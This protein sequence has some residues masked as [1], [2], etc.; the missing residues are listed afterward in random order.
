MDFYFTLY[1]NLQHDNLPASIYTDLSSDYFV[2]LLDALNISDT[3]IYCLSIGPAPSK[4]GNLA[5]ARARGAGSPR[6]AQSLLLAL[7]RDYAT[8]KRWPWTREGGGER[9]T[10]GT[11]DVESSRPDGRAQRSRGAR[12]DSVLRLASAVT[13]PMPAPVAR[14]HHGPPKHCYLPS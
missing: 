11:R 7:L 2:Q 3:I 5:R 14:G 10:T 12:N 8:Q 13:W 6:T 4:R 9:T 1:C